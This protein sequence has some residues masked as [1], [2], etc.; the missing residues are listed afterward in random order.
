VDAGIVT[1]TRARG[2]RA[3]K[4]SAQNELIFTLK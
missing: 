1:S 3:T 4:V 2:G